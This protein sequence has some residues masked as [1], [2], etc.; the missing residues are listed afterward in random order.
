MTDVG[1]AKTIAEAY[2]LNDAV[3]A[4]KAGGS[5]SPDVHVEAPLFS[6]DNPN[7]VIETIKQAED[8]NGIIVRLYESFRTRGKVRLSAAIPIA[9]AEKV[10]LLE[11]AMDQIDISDGAAVFNIRPFE[12]VTLRI[13]TA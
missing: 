6:S 1:I 11:E 7:I 10:N 13:V 9:R 4:V 5:A 8:G 12:I 3:I 2:Q